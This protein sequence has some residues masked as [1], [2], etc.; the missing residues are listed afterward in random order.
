MKKFCMIF[1]SAVGIILAVNTSYAA[2]DIKVSV[3]N[4][5]IDF[6]GDQPPIIQNGRTLV[7]FRAVFEK[8]GA[9]VDWDNDNK[10]CK[11][12]LTDTTVSICID[13]TTVAVNGKATV[14]SDVPAQIINGR[15]MVPIS[16]D[17]AK[18]I[19]FKDAKVNTSDVVNLRIKL[20]REYYGDVYDIEFYSN[21]VEYSYEIEVSTGKIVSS[22]KEVKNIILT[23][24]Q[25]SPTNDI[26]SDDAV[27]IALNDSGLQKS[28]I[29]GLKTEYDHDDGLDIYEIEFYYNRTE[30]SYEINAANG[31]IISKEIDKD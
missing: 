19:A 20:D 29:N 4:E 31:D 17:E 2:D 28:Q 10:I 21:N 5:I 26:S 12:S 13:S 11:A 8:M 25:P 27:Q 9:S 6:S 16:E 30:Y 22:D 7:P 3:N 23:P 18:E 24:A 1:L 15:T 14:K